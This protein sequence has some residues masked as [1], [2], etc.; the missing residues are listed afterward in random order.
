MTAKDRKEGVLAAFDA[1]ADDYV[2]K[3][4]DIRELHARIK[5]KATIVKALGDVPII[6][7]YPQRLDQVFMNILVNAGQGTTFTIF[8]GRKKSVR[9]HQI[10]V[11][12]KTKR[13]DNRIQIVGTTDVGRIVFHFLFV[14]IH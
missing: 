6:H 9:F 1:G 14:L 10:E 5:Y 4:Y 7:A 8:H 13:L 11:K 2:A 3:P 12:D